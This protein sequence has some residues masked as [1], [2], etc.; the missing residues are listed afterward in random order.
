[1]EGAGPSPGA[2][3]RSS[4]PPCLGRARRAR[5]ARNRARRRTRLS[6]ARPRERDDIS[7]RRRRRDTRAAGGRTCRAGRRPRRERRG[8]GRRASRNRTRTRAPPGDT[9]SASRRPRRHL[10]ERES[11]SVRRDRRRRR[12]RDGPRRA[13][14]ARRARARRRIYRPCAWED[15]RNLGSRRRLRIECA[16]RRPRAGICPWWA[17]A[18]A[19]GASCVAPRRRT[20][21]RNWCGRL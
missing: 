17:P 1:M 21:V 14:G 10:R 2:G 15:A 6:S 13:R 7:T 3:P 11:A 9:A 16:R 18:W 8:R 4:S 12:A 5:I 19:S 20:A